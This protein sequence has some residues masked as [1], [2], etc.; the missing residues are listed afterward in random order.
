MYRVLLLKCNQS[1]DYTA[2]L[3]ATSMGV[4]EVILLIRLNKE[5]VSDLLSVII[6]SICKRDLVV[7]ACLSADQCA[8]AVKSHI[9]SWP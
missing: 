6:N 4:I 3:L 2:S 7:S 1:T 5:Y 9:R 8:F